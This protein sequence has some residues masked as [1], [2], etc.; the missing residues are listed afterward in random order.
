[1]T[2]VTRF[3][4]S[5][6]GMM[7]TGNVRTALYNYLF[8]KHNKGKFLLRIEDTDKDRS[9]KEAVDVI[10][11]DLKW[12]G[13]EPD[14]EAVFQSTRLSRHAEVANELLAKGQ[15]YKCFAT[16]DDI[17]KFRTQNPHAKFQSP[18]RDAASSSHPSDQPFAIRIKAPKTGTITVKDHVL[19][20]TTL[21]CT[22]LDDMVMLRSDGTPTYMLAVVV[23]DHDADVTHII[24]GADHF[25]NSFRQM[26]IYNAMGWSVPEFAHLPLILDKAGKKLSKRTG[27]LSVGEYREMGYLPE[28]VR[29]HLLRLG[30]SHGDDEIISTDQAIKWFSLEHIGKSP[31]RFDIDKLNFI[32]AHYIRATD[33]KY[34]AEAIANILKLSNF[35]IIERILR[36]MEGL[37]NRSHTMVELADNA[38]IYVDKV[39]L[40]QKSKDVLASFGGELLPK[41]K[42]LFSETTNWTK[43]SVQKS[44]EEFAIA[45]GK[46]PSDIMQTLRA[47]VVGTFSS[48]SIYEVIEIL[49]KDETIK[50]ISL[51][52][53]HT[54]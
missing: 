23:D 39:P 10:F 6:T 25:T 44:C 50:R 35:D 53:N 19:G 48:P 28:A 36:G 2:I 24:R 38:K 18:W 1:M 5:P 17:Q 15:A 46:K 31:A 42:V 3:A 37:K 33:H 34:L 12:L 26:M 4:P 27:A 29:N 16:Q 45:E 51:Y 7:H 47:G 40:D 41:L 9:T 52:P 20:E 8:S 49:G 21:E 14:D 32:N 43:D 22:E 11:N 13:I 30:W 54:K